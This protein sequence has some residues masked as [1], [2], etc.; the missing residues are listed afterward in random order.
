MRNWRPFAILLLFTC[1]SCG[2]INEREERALAEQ[3]AAVRSEYAPDKRTALFDITVAESTDGYILMGESNLPEAIEVLK[4]NLSAENVRFT[5]HIDVLPS[6]NLEGKTAALVNISV[7]NLRSEPKHSAE[8]STQATLGTPLNVLKK[9]EG[10]YYV[11]TPDNYLAWVDDGGI[12]PMEPKYLENWKT[13][14]KIIY[15]K[16]YGH[17]Y[18]GP[19]G[20]QP[21]SDLV[22][23]DILEIIKNVD[24]HYI[25]RYPD[26]RKAYVLKDESEEYDQ[27][28]EKLNPNADSLIAT[29]KKLMGV[30]YL[31]GGTSTKGMDCSGF[32]KT[33]FFLNGMVIPRDASQQ[34]HTGKA[35]DSV[36]DFGKLA[37]GDLLFFGRKATDSTAEKTVHVGMWIGNNEFIHASEMVRVSS[38]DQNA[39]NFDE[40]NRDR[41]LRTQRVLEEEDDAVL[42]LARMP[43]VND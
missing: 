10:W 5:N 3:I 11:Q 33:I 16:T 9:Q 26:D 20:E 22:A 18:V 29:S 6:S 32:T 35:I 27:W 41:Y 28:L 40:F 34:V 38:M 13:T 8:L 23:G 7:A 24:D 31:W 19:E 36:G 1:V 12:E 21:V 17:S 2:F 37:K 39:E 14:P 43:V 4:K 30:P 25:V 15:T 42:N